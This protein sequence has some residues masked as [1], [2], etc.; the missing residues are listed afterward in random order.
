MNVFVIS[1]NMPREQ[2]TDA[3]KL[4]AEYFLSCFSQDNLDITEI[5]NM[6]K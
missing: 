5:T 2:I 1:E 3:A 6:M 4:S